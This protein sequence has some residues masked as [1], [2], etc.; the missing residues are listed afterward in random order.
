MGGRT[1]TNRVE[2]GRL[3]N[4]WVVTRKLCTREPCPD[5]RRLGKKRKRKKKRENQVCSVGHTRCMLGL[6]VHA[7]L[8]P[9]V[10]VSKAQD[11]NSIVALEYFNFTLIFFSKRTKWKSF[12][13]LVKMC[14]QPGVDPLKNFFLQ[15]NSDIFRIFD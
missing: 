15:L 5:S 3:V 10:G 13:D 7:Q 14:S 4:M 12:K 1:W 2:S 11:G 8:F 6:N 9:K